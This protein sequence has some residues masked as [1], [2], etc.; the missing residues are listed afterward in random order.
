[1]RILSAVLALSSALGI[2][3]AQE[4]NYPTRP[5]N[6]IVPFAPGGSSDI[7][8]RVLE[9][10][11]ARNLGQPIVILNRPGAAGNIGMEAVAKAA[12]DGYTIVLGNS[13]NYVRTY[14]EFKNLK[15]SLKDFTPI[16]LVGETPLAIVV[17]PGLPVNSLRE[18]IEYARENPNKISY[19]AQG[20]RSLDIHMIRNDQKITMNEVPYAGGS[21]QLMKDIVGGHIQLVAATTSS[22]ISYIRSGQ[23]KALALMSETRDAGL[24]DVPTVAE[25]GYPQFVSNLWFGFATPAGV[26]EPIVKKLHGAVR[27]AVKSDEV[28][29]H[30]RKLAVL[31]KASE[32][33][34]DFR[35]FIEAE[36]GRW[37]KVV[38]AIE[39]KK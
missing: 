13:L 16:S 38:D 27:E 4:S 31:P 33:P 9:P 6:L 32:T 14:L 11:M 29:A 25:A 20:P 17:H 1:M 3:V 5:I 34:A 22:V 24:P 18:L 8:A 2:A 19:G 28:V 36:F 21:G 26:P 23:L 12:P 10:V 7:L 37:T 15:F 39:A 30:F 35:N